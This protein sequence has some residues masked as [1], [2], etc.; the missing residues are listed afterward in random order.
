MMAADLIGTANALTAQ[1]LTP[2]VRLSVDGFEQ[3]VDSLW[4]NLWPALRR[5]FAF[6]LSF[7]PNDL[8]EHPEPALVCT[9]E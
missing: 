9:P 1:G 3:L 4:K 5:T 2:V 8:V 7:G 6:R